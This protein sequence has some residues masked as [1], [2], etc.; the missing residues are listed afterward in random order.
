MI[1][2]ARFGRVEGHGTPDGLGGHGHAAEGSTPGDSGGVVGVIVDISRRRQAE[3]AL[4]EAKE[5]AEDAN[6]AKSSFLAAMS[7]EIRTPMNGVVGM[8]ELLAHTPLDQDQR[9]MVGT[10]RESAF[11]LLTIIDDILDFSKIEAGKLD[12]ERVPTSVAEILEGVAD[13]LAPGAAKKDLDLVSFVEPGVPA[14]VL[15]DPVRLRQVLFNLGGNAIKFTERGKVVIAVAVER[16]GDEEVQLRFRVTDSG[17]GIAEE[18]QVKLFQAFTQAESSTTRRFGGTGLGLSICQRLVDLMGGE[19]GIDSELG[20]GATFWFRVVLPVCPAGVATDD[21]AVPQRPLPDL[22]G[23]EVLVTSADEEVVDFVSRYLA[24][25]GASART[26]YTLSGTVDVAV[27]DGRSLGRG[28]NTLVEGVLGGMPS[29]LSDDGGPR[30][31]IFGDA[32]DA[33][34]G[35][36]AAIT[37]AK[38]LRRERLIRAVAVAAGRAAPETLKESRDNTLAAGRTPPTIEAARSQGRLVLLAEDHPVNRRVIERQL[39]T[40]G[41]AVELAVHGRDALERWQGDRFGLV[42]TDCH[43]PEMDG[44]ELTA[45][46]REAE[47]AADT[48]GRIPI[49][50]ATAN[51]LAGEAE[52]CLA[53]GM[54]DYLSKPVTLDALKRALDRWLPFNDDLPE[55]ASAAVDTPRRTS[56]ISTD[57]PAVDHS[58]LDAMCGGDVDFVRE[59]LGDFIKINREVVDL[60]SQAVAE[61]NAHGVAEIAHKLKGSSGTA[62]ARRLAAITGDLEVA[63]E[64]AAWDEIQRLHLMAVDEF[65]RVVD[66]VDKL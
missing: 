41:Y 54:D 51:A 8:L 3:V 39:N 30:L 31:V 65:Q 22:Q 57:D 26:V 34:P 63:G 36:D 13:T 6:R 55:I 47:A 19:I 50:A 33:N 56:E 4:S 62:G 37:I 46:I 53:A 64:G 49:I 10:V 16:L 1:A 60:L 15:V 28:E 25:A 21:G 2:K 20:R 44:F 24:D 48:G 58:V 23:V 27:A 38:P 17:I 29:G 11:A 7:H 12:L 45:A 40:L 35:S 9:Q 42:I 18:N 66:H 52:N 43:M 61:E 59:L 32:G 14:R 5:E